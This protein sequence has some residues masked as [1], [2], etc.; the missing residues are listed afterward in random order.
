MNYF[1]VRVEVS[2]PG[3]QSGPAAGP[4]ACSSSIIHRFRPVVSQWQIK[5]ASHI[6]SFFLDFP[7]FHSLL[8]IQSL[9]RLGW[10]LAF[11]VEG[12]MIPERF[13]DSSTKA[14]FV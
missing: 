9:I 14:S 6:A 2:N 11:L 13:N 8:G 7:I 10:E 4:R 5:R 12:V 3:Q 1:V